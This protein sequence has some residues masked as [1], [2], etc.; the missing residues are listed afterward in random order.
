ML[1]DMR[2]YNARMS[3]AATEEMRDAIVALAKKNR[4]SLSQ[5]IMIAI[6]EHL[7]KTEEEERKVKEEHL[8]ELILVVWKQ[9]KEE[10][11]V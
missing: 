6:Q 10:G 7:D 5:E 1:E 2:E 8:R 11:L 9:L 3:F 4:R